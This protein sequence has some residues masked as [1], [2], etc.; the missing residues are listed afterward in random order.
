MHVGGAVW[1]L[2]HKHSARLNCLLSI[3]GV[4][5]QSIVIRVLLAGGGRSYHFN[6]VRSSS[7]LSIGILGYSL[8]S[9]L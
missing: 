4:G 3:G 1:T 2:L 5:A 8:T 7:L 9:H 6:L